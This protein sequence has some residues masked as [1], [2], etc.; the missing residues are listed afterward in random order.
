MRDPKAYVDH[1]RNDPHSPEQRLEHPYDFVSLPDAPARAEAVPHN[2]YPDDRWS[3]TLTLVY[4]LETPM[5]AGSGVFETAEECGLRGGARPV[6]GISRSLGRPILGGSSWKGAVRARFEAITRSRLGQRTRTQ[7]E[8]AFK[9]PEALKKGD[10]KKYRFDLDDPKVRASEP[11]G[12]VRRFEDLAGK[13][14]PA[15]SLFGCMGYRGRVMAGEGAVEGPRAEEPLKVPALDSPVAHRLAKPGGLV[16][17]GGSKYRIT[18]VE[19]RKFY[20]DGDVMHHRVVDGAYGSKEVYEWV[21]SVPAGSTI[22]VEVQLQSLSVAEVGALLV[23]AGHGS[24]V[25]ILRFGGYKSAGL[26]KVRLESATAEL[27]K[28]RST[29]RWKRSDHS[30]SETVFDLDASVEEAR[31]SLIDGERLKELHTVTTLRRPNP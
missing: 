29:R 24:E 26:G 8:P 4:R 2:R 20:Y 6:R 13:L 1:G 9:V 17:S 16:H 12:T 27:S 14:S 23:S 7:P 28:G 5:H 22:T 18:A 10:A 30:P 31:K 19:G 25:G 15:E 3:G 21:D 11:M